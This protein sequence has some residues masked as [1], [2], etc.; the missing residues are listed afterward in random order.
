MDF[1]IRHHLRPLFLF[2]AHAQNR[3]TRKAVSRFFLKCGHLTPDLLRHAV[4]DSEGK[5]HHEKAEAFA[6]FAAHLMKTY[7]QEFLPAS[8]APPVIRGHDLIREF[9]LV[10]SPLFGKILAHVR[11]ECL[12]NNIRNRKDALEIVRNFLSLH[13]PLTRAPH[14]NKGDAF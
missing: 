10:P 6:G 3:L 1:I 2:T 12:A 4:A 13:P 14:S 7:F 9:G 8:M 5:G 11:A